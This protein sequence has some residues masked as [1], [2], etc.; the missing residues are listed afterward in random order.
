MHGASEL[1]TEPEA[2]DSDDTAE[3]DTDTTIS[4]GASERPVAE[5]K[6]HMHLHPATT[7]SRGHD[8]S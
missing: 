5:E 2:S 1:D 8:C 3:Q 4:S 7:Q 6:P